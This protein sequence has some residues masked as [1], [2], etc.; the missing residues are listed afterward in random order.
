VFIFGDKCV[1]CCG[2]E[3]TIE[4]IIEAIIEATSIYYDDG[5]YADAYGDE[6]EK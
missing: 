6:N 3:S 1:F 5:D 4:A 2:I